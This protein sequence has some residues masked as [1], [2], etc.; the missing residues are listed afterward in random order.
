MAAAIA[1]GLALVGTVAAADSAPVAA[2]HEPA[3]PI[4]FVHGATGSAAQYDTQ[5][6]RWA[7]NHYPNL[8]RAI[9]R[10]SAVGAV[11]NPLLDA[12]FD[13]VMAETGDS[14]IYV[15][16]HSQGVAV[17]NGYLN[18]L[19]ERAARVAKYIAIDSASGPSPGVCP[20]G[21]DA[22][23][24]WNVPC[25]GL[26]A[27]GDPSRNFGNLHN[28]YFPEQGHT[29]VVGSAESFA[30][31]YEWLTGHEP[32][33]TLVLPEPPGQ[34]AIAGR[35]LNFPANTGIDGATVQLWEVNGKTGV[36]TTS[37][38]LAQTMVGAN[39]NFGPWRV[40]GHQ[41]HEL[42]VIRQAPGGELYQQHFYYEPWTRSH[43]LIRLNLS[44]IG[45]ALSNAIARGPHATVSV[46]R[47]KEW[48][49]NNPVDETNIDSLEIA[50]TSPSHGDQPPTEIINSN[51]APYT[52]STI[53]VIGFDIGVDQMSD[54]SELQPLGAFLSG[55]DIYMPAT[56]PPDGTVV[57]AHQQRLTSAPQVINTPN[58]MSEARHGMTVTFR[59]W[60]QDITTWGQ[61]KSAKPS[62]CK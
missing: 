37:E 25:M 62:P 2:G 5:A 50:T 14:Q 48:W 43:Y 15:V 33:T 20:G 31:Q 9:D 59:D 45:S 54:P 3:L 53:A 28:V 29:Q 30:A 6:L 35:A 1:A 38:P 40:N 26:W 12:F 36:R 60:M 10:V 42:T 55:V 4:V 13:N 57:F 34:V 17:M 8:V 61:C 18:S 39:G 21:T 32:R 44:P 52:A 16:A 46:V 58:W 41:R 19:P 56:D 24:D 7:S 22:N 49:G 23:G 47:Q 51:T 11:I 27:R